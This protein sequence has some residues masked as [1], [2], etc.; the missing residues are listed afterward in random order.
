MKNNFLFFF[1]L[2]ALM[3]I[4]IQGYAYSLPKEATV[5]GGIAIISISLKEKP[6]AFFQ[7]QAVMVCLSRLR[8]EHISL[9][10][11]MAI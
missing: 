11:W 8:Q 10:L 1:K 2:I 6:K 7:E 5:P 4:S 3:S 9:K